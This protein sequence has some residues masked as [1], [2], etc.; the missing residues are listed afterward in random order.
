MIAG[1]FARGPFKTGGDVLGLLPNPGLIEGVA[2][3]ASPREGDL[4]PAEWAKAMKDLGILPKLHDLFGL[5]FLGASSGVAYTV[6][7]AFVGFVKDTYGAAAVRDWYGGKALPDVTGASW[8]DL[9]ARFLAALDAFVL[10]A[11]PAGC[12][13]ASLEAL[14]HDLPTIA[15]DV[16]EFAF[17]TAGITDQGTTSLRAFCRELGLPKCDAK[18]GDPL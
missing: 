16:G 13:N 10:V 11:E 5:A 18:S 14:A 17:W 3:A 6:S 1:S 8:A 12:P 7:G 2:V 4:S 9:E 15:T